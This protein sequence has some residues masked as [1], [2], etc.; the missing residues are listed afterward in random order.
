MG[1]VILTCMAVAFA[2]I[3]RRVWWLC[4]EFDAQLA[5]F[6]M[7]TKET[8]YLNKRQLAII[9]AAEKMAGGR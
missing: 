9:E 1:E 5:E 2:V 3:A 4:E 6:E 7:L 8:A